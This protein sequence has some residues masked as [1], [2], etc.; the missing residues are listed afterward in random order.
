[1][2]RLGLLVSLTVLLVAL[3]AVSAVGEDDP[4][5]PVKVRPIGKI[6][7]AGQ[8]ATTVRSDLSDED[9][10]KQAGLSAN[11][12]GP[13]IEYLKVRTLTEGDQNKI[14]EVIKKFGADD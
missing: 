11:E 9:A 5:P 10:L 12:A 4:P 2:R 1:M 7:K 6:G 13:L 14:G 3:V 8:P